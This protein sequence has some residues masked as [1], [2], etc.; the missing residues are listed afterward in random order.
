MKTLSDAKHVTVRE[1]LCNTCEQWA[2]LSHRSS[3]V[4]TRFE[5]ET[6]LEE[7]QGKDS[8]KKERKN[9]NMSSVI[10]LFLLLLLWSRFKLVYEGAAGRTAV[11]FFFFFLPCIIKAEQRFASYLFISFFKLNF[12]MKINYLT[13]R[14]KI[15]NLNVTAPKSR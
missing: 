5:L 8:S 6:Q 15:A 7:A 12:L 13:W 3:D 4:K 14:K 2:S 11:H 1:H 9:N 10:L